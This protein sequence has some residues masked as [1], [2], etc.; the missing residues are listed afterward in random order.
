MQ[1]EFSISKPAWAGAI[2]AGLGG[3]SKATWKLIVVTNGADVKLLDNALFPL[4]GAGFTLLALSLILS[5]L[6]REKWIWP[7]ALVIISGFYAWSW[8]KLGADHP[9]AWAFVLLGM[10]VGFSVLF[11]L[12][13]TGVS[14]VRKKFVAG[15]LIFASIAGSFYLNYLARLPDQTLALQWKEEIVNTASQGILLIGILLLAETMFRN[16][17]P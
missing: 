7:L 14:L 3:L 9:R 8:S 16:A 6:N 5:L 15:V 2:F 1:G 13:L 10:T 4:L 11:S 12:S 17:K